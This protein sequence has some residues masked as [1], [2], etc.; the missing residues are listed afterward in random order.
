MATGSSP[1]FL[2]CPQSP[3]PT[4]TLRPQRLSLGLECC[5]LPGGSLALL[6]SHWCSFQGAVPGQN[7][8]TLLT[9]VLTPDLQGLLAALA[10]LHHCTPG[11]SSVLLAPCLLVSVQQALGEWISTL[12]ALACSPG[13]GTCFLMSL[14]LTSGALEK[15]PLPASGSGFY[16]TPV[17]HPSPNLG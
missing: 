2:L 14:S 6:G 3:H 12:T 13:Q 17:H 7:H 5:W 15:L 16:Q 11:L 1:S 4:I 8:S 9:S 10:S